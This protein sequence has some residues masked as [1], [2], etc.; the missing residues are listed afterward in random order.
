MVN[1]VEKRWNDPGAVRGAARYLAAV[2]VVT[3]AVFGVCVLWASGRDACAGD[4]ML[5]DTAAQGVT[6]LAPA[7]ALLLGAIGAFVQTFRVWR[8]GGGWPIWQGAGWFALVLFMAYL[9]IGGGA[10]AG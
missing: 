4:R 10:L 8:R 1:D 7:A 5:C 9:S 2:L 3:A 6:L